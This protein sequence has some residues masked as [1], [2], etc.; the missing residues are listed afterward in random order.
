MTYFTAGKCRGELAGR[1]ELNHLPFNDGSVHAEKNSDS[2]SEDPLVTLTRGT[3]KFVF[4]AYI[5][6]TDPKDTNVEEGLDSLERSRED[7]GFSSKCHGIVTGGA[8]TGRMMR[9]APHAHPD[10]LPNGLE[11]VNF[12]EFQPGAVA[13]LLADCCAPLAGADW[14]TGLRYNADLHQRCC[15][16]DH[17]YLRDVVAA[18]GGASSAGYRDRLFMVSAGGI[19]KADSREWDVPGGAAVLRDDAAFHMV[20]GGELPSRGHSA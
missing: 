4:R 13:K 10:L 11:R 9:Q 14:G 12:G 3:S 19:R 20:W 18:A 15:S 16:A 2:E 5:W 6:V 8:S 7:L 17:D 1:T